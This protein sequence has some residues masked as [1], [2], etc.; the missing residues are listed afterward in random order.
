MKPICIIIS[1]FIIGSCK[2][3]EEL[4]NY[5]VSGFV[6][7]VQSLKAIN[8]ALINAYEID[9]PNS[10]F[11]GGGESDS[12]GYY[13]FRLNSSKGRKITFELSGIGLYQLYQIK[14]GG[15]QLM[16]IVLADDRELEPLNLILVPPA[17]VNLSFSDSF[18]SADFDYVKL[19]SNN[20]QRALNSESLDSSIIIQVF[21][22]IQD[23]VSI[24][25]IDSYTDTKGN[26]IE[27]V[28]DSTVIQFNIQAFDTLALRP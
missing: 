11:I 6:Q 21:G 9:Y 5:I 23:S 8:K 15:L 4:N 10:S 12:S 3:K 26:L 13:S 7:E 25:K 18:K 27:T 24:Y 19:I 17:Y 16:E 2:K 20:Y 22:N 28:L 14:Q 1:L